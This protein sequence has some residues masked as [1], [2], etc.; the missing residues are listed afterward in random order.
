MRL[1]F[2]LKPR[3]RNVISVS[4]PDEEANN[5]TMRGAGVNTLT[6]TFLTHMGMNGF[7]RCGKG[8]S[9][10]KTTGDNFM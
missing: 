1:S 7:L 3:F 9:D 5:N 4:L 6:R 2:L 8:I 10:P